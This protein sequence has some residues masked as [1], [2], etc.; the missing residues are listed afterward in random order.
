MIAVLKEQRTGG[1]GD[2]F[3]EHLTFKR[4]VLDLEKIDSTGFRMVEG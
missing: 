3:G 1:C 2:S 4:T